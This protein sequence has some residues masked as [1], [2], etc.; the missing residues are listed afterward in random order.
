MRTTTQ[1]RRA[2]M[3]TSRSA[4]ANH[5]AMLGDYALYRKRFLWRLARMR[6]RRL[7]RLIFDFLRFFSDPMVLSSPVSAIV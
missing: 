5:A 4:E 3:K 1:T 7:C 6:L 2:S